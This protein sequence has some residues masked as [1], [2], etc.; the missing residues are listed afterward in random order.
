MLQILHN[1]RCSKSRQTLKLIE[2]AGVTPEIILYLENPLGRDELMSLIAKL[3]LS[4]ARDVIRKGEKEYK[5]LGLKAE[6]SETK[7]VEA[8]AGHPR[9]LERPIVIQGS[10]A[11]IGRP[12]ENVLELLP[13]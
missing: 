8:L 3:N 13:K 2:D 6:T 12:P 1:P 11:I 5:E 9:L 10:K 7:L 4:S